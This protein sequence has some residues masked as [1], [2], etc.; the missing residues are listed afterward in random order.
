MILTCGTKLFPLMSIELPTK[1]ETSYSNHMFRVVGRLKPGVTAAQGAADL[2]LISHL[3][4][5]C[6]DTVVPIIA[7][8]F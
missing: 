3:S 7:C 8:A 6:D 5:R 2:S 4:T 1:W